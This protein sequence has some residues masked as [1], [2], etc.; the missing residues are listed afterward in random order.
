MEVKM[1]VEME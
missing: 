1:E